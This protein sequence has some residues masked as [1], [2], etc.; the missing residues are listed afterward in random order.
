M[1][2]SLNRSHPKYREMPRVPPDQ[3]ENRTILE[4]LRRH[5]E[6]K[7]LRSLSRRNPATIYVWAC[8]AAPGGR[9]AAIRVGG[10]W[11]HSV[12]Q[13]DGD[14]EDRYRVVDDPDEVDALIADARAALLEPPAFSLRRLA[15]DAV[16][17]GLNGGFPDR[18]LN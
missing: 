8:S 14:L 11:K 16:I 13:T 7:A 1:S 9:L 3:I 2:I 17:F 15:F 12:G 5:D 10:R 18:T 6:A 4:T